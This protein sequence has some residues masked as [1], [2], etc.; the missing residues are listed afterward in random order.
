MIPPIKKDKIVYYRGIREEKEWEVEIP[1]DNKHY[2]I[3]VTAKSGSWYPLTITEAKFQS[4]N[5][6][7][8]RTKTIIIESAKEF[9]K[10]NLIK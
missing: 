6:L 3:L 1:Y 2:V 5:K 7:S 8:K 10:Q 4:L 9:V